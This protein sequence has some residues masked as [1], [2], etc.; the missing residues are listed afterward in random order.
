MDKQPSGALGPRLFRA[1]LL[2][3]QSVPPSSSWEDSWRLYED[4]ALLVDANG[5]IKEVG[6]YD[7]IAGNDPQV[8]TVN[9]STKIIAP[10]FIDAHVHL[11]QYQAAGLY[12]KELLDWL[13]TYIFPAER[14]FTPA[15]AD[16]LCPV[17]FDRLLA[18][19]VTTAAIYS[20]SSAA[21]TD[22]VFEWAREKHLRAIIGKVMMDRNVPLDLA[23]SSASVAFD[24][25]EELCRKWHQKDADQLLY[26]AF[27]P[28]FAPSCSW[29]LMK[30][31]GRLSRHLQESGVYVQTHLSENQNE[32]AW[33]KELF[34][35]A[36]DYTDVYE[37]TGL[38]GPKTLLA[39]AIYISARERNVLLDAQAALVHCP[40]SN[41]FLKSGL[42]P[43]SDLL[44]MKQK[45]ALGSDVAGGPTLCPFSVMQSAIYVHNSRRFLTAEADS[46]LT[47]ATVF[48][49]ATL[50]GARALGL[51]TITGSLEPG[52]HADFIVL[53]VSSFQDLPSDSGLGELERLLSRLV[54]LGDDRIVD[55]TYVQG[56]LC[57]KRQ[58]SER[59]Q[60][61]M[62]VSKLAWT[63]WHK[64]VK[65]RQHL[66]SGELSLDIF[67]A[68][69]Y[70]VN[71]TAAV[72]A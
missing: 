44:H 2:T 3:P 13:E 10:G 17:F 60:E 55:Q 69:L 52:K 50:G 12:G 19:G 65:I 16:S 53:D 66:K 39:H 30:N 5:K 61:V 40:T 63:L 25:S 28:R 43:L 33:V 42:M 36:Q 48:Y 29:Q 49:L 59:R 46:D 20:S 51:D 8:P 11:P 72:A 15:A 67:A 56:R 32:V 70:N 23:D 47:P 35:E 71:G 54:F 41:L 7:R 38:L 34:P 27:T 14:R 31:V 21:S 57:Y 22:R 64:V 9:L 24:E 4:G 6:H 1:K 58:E 68:D 45:V 37:K 62:N 26:Y 18:N